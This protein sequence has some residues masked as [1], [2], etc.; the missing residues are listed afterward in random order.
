MIEKEKTEARDRKREEKKREG[1]KRDR[2][3]RRTREG[4]KERKR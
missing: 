3:D 4:E 1:K 2:S